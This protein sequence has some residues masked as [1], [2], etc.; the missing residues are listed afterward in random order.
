MRESSGRP[1]VAGDIMAR[2]AAK[3]TRRGKTAKP[4][5]AAA[6]TVRK[7]EAR[8]GAAAA[9]AAA[10]ARRWT[11]LAVLLVLALLALRLA[12]NALELVPV[13]FDE[14]QYW[15]YG[16]ELAWGYYSKPPGVGAAIRLTTEIF[17][18]TLFG[19][20][21]AS[22]IAHALIA[23]MI[24]LTARRIWEA[25]TGFWAA[26]AY[27][28]APGVSASAMIVSTDPVMMVGWAVALYAMVRAG[29]EGR[30]RWWVLM[31][32]AIG[33]G[34]LAKYTILAFAAG[35]LGYGLVSARARDWRG[36]AVAAGVA[37]LVVAPNLVWNAAHSFATLT[38]VAEDAAPGTGL[39]NPGALAEFLGAQL[40]VIGPVVFLAIL[41][42]LW[43][44]RD[45]R[46]EPAM[47]LMAWLTAPLLLGMIVLAFV[48]RAQ[49]NWAAPAYVAGSILAARFLLA[50]DWARVLGW[51]QFG[52]GAVAAVGL[53]GLAA[54]YE[55]RAL[56]LPR[57]PDPFKKM[58]LSEP[59]CALALGAMAEEG[60]EVLLSDNR[61]RLSECMFLGGLGWDSVAVWNEDRLIDSHH[62]LVAGLQPGDQRL[63][64]LAVI[65]DAGEKAQ[66]FDEA[67]E[68]DSGRFA[69]HADRE[70]RYSLWVVSGFNGY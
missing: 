34:A 68:I 58:R 31:G 2:A 39:F 1:A 16:Q 43:R 54:L 23:W 8:R 42:A 64:L 52:L 62:E 28:A 10:E 50:R 17:G 27:S 45:W 41:W 18:T 63:M 30:L 19:L 15:A 40:G 3:T 70:F 29:E 32:I 44:W 33:L 5:K 47:R 59:F 37:G 51:G 4:K 53:Y 24:F 48:T 26:A 57:A 35:A 25:R 20:R 56:D 65:G 38:H 61:R 12:V 11:R 7:A 21:L 66:A 49:P 69:T 67:R 22:P 6:R 13:H 36:A 55:A 46:A 9:E 60:A 14:G